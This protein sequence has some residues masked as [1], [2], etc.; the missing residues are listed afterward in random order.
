MEITIEG[1]K[2]ES[3]QNGSFRYD[4]WMM[5]KIRESG[6]A[7][8][9][10]DGETQEAFMERIATK[11]YESGAGLDLL[12]GLFVPVGTNLKDWTPKLAASTAEFFGAVTDPD[13]KQLLRTQMASALFYFFVTALASSTTSP[14]SSPQTTGEDERHETGDA[15]AGETGGI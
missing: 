8:Q 9:L 6:L 15:L 7:L 10:I 12:G 13:A 1:R 14:K 3:V 11:A 4:I 5:N 2:F